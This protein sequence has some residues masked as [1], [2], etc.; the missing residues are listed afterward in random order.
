MIIG[1]SLIA[2]PGVA[3][4]YRSP[5][6]NRVSDGATFVVEVIHASS[7]DCEI[8]MSFEE[9]DAQD[10]DGA[11]TPVGADGTADDKGTYT[12]STVPTAT[13]VKQLLRCMLEL[14]SASEAIEWMHVRVNPPIWQPN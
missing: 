7:T 9:K 2:L 5:W 6:F 10:S 4:V 14:E 13:G 12:S 1:Q 3:T 11:A 8:T